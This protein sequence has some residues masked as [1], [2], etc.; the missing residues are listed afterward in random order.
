MA[1]PLPNISTDVAGETALV[2]GASFRL[3]LRFAK[4]LVNCG[5]K[6]AISLLVGSDRSGLVPDP[7]S[8]DVGQNSRR[9]SPRIEPL[10]RQGRQIRSI[11][12]PIALSQTATLDH[13]HQWMKSVP[14]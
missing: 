11:H 4:V 8:R 9:D 10:L 13:H 7:G 1:Y 12:R 14:N 3:G 2:T 5:A 6:I